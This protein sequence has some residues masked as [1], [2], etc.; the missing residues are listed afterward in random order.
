[1]KKNDILHFAV[2]HLC[3]AIFDLR[4]RYLADLLAGKA[5]T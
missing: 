3:N 2:G 5:V 1:V 4:A